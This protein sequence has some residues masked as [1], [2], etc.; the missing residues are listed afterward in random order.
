MGLKYSR[1][2]GWK[3]RAPTLNP[4]A[5][6]PRTAWDFHPG[7]ISPFHPVRSR[8]RE[9][10]A[11]SPGRTPPREDPGP[12]PD[13][14]RAPDTTWGPSSDRCPVA[15][16]ENLCFWPSLLKRFREPAERLGFG[17]RSQR[18]P[19]REKKKRKKS[20][21]KKSPWQFSPRSTAAFPQQ[22]TGQMVRKQLRKTKPPAVPQGQPG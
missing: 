15:K 7:T 12:A 22:L 5:G 10:A 6:E 19:S 11:W 4:K 14:G 18:R 9:P 20:E 1:S 13:P 21:K 17:W 2:Q 3:T 16:S 8:F